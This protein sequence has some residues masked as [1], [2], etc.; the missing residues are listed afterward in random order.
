MNGAIISTCRPFS[1]LFPSDPALGQHECVLGGC[2]VFQGLRASS[3]PVAPKF[4]RFC[5]LTFFP[6]CLIIRLMRG[7]EIFLLRDYVEQLFFRDFRYKDGTKLNPPL[8]TGNLSLQPGLKR[9][10]KHP[11]VTLD[12]SRVCTFTTLRDPPNSPGLCPLAKRSGRERCSS[13]PCFFLFAP[14]LSGNR[15]LSPPPPISFASFHGMVFQWKKVNGSHESSL[16]EFRSPLSSRG[17]PSRPRF[18]GFYVG[19]SR[20]KFIGSFGAKG[21]AQPSVLDREYSPVV[22]LIFLTS[23]AF[24]QD[25]PLIAFPVVILSYG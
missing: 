4:P 14:F 24:G 18:L 10:L 11:K 19:R 5:G 25:A 17:L 7:E 16:S 21:L 8:R 3:R 20:R 9:V 6:G 2:Q 22:A 23:G 15:T 13:R 12:R 1:S